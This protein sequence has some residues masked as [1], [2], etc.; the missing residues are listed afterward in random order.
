MYKCSK[1]DAVGSVSYSDPFYGDTRRASFCLTSEDR[2]S[3]AHVYREDDS[4]RVCF[5]REHPCSPDRIL[6]WAKSYDVCAKFTV[7]E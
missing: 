5:P 2:G 6:C 1:S 3:I 7:T 4:V